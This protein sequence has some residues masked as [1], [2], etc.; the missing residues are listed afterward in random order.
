MK[1]FRGHFFNWYDTQTLQPL[2]PQY[3]STVDSGNLVGLLLTLKAGLRELGDRTVIQTR[4]AEGISDTLRVLHEVL[5]QAYLEREQPLPT[6]LGAAVTWRQRLGECLDGQSQNYRQ[7]VP[8]AA[9][10]KVLLSHLVRHVD[11]FGDVD[12]HWW[13]NALLRQFDQMIVSLLS[14]DLPWLQLE[15]PT[16]AACNHLTLAAGHA[17]PRLLAFFATASAIPTWQELAALGNEAQVIDAAADHATQASEHEAHAWL[18]SLAA[19]VRSAAAVAKNLLHEAAT[20]ASQCDEFSQLEYDFLYDKSRQLLSIGYAVTEHRRDVGCYDLL[21]SEARLGSFVAIAQGLLPQQHWFALGRLLTQVHSG[22][23]LLSW[24]GS[25]F[26]YLMPALVMPSFPGSLLDRTYHNVVSRQIEYGKQRGVP[27]GISESGY[28]TTDMNLNYQYRAFGIPGLGFKRGLVDDLV[29]APYATSMALMVDPAAATANLQVLASKGFI[30][31]YGFYEAIDY[32]ASRLV[33]GQG[34]ALLRSYMAHH[35]GMSFLSLAYHLLDQP[36]QRRFMADPQVQATELLLQERVPK[37]TPFYPHA[38]EVQGGARPQPEQGTPLRVITTA[39]TPRPEVQLLSNGRYTVMVTQAGGG[40]SRW[41][42]LALTRWRED[43]SCD[44]WGSFCY[45][46]DLGWLG[47]NFAA[48][49]K[50]SRCIRR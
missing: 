46:R 12:S 42:G 45:V 25:M 19:C 27:W 28:N 20:L 11:N 10:A 44:D 47:R 8:L 15:A 29:I 37:F 31:K 41:Q 22:S 17:A 3:V 26:E 14:R 33:Q 5:E 36:M 2:L 23:A 9:E 32:T 39:Q 13:V 48:S 16:P 34:E 4:L 7:L 50:A 30:G 1:R 43:P 18:T 6:G 49:T 24:S 35:E 21:A 38:P 40:Y